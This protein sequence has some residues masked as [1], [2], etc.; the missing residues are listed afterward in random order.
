MRKKN[1]NW[2]FQNNFENVI[3]NSDFK[4]TGVLNWTAVSDG[5]VNTQKEVVGDRIFR[6]MGSWEQ[7]S[8]GEAPC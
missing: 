5:F 7:T 8:E 6:G 4:I 1:V 2:R 3:N